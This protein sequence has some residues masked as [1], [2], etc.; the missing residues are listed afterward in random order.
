M[1]DING[2]HFAR[3]IGNAAWWVF[4]VASLI[5][6]GVTWLHGSSDHYQTASFTDPSAVTYHGAYTP[7]DGVTMSKA[8]S[9]TTTSWFES[10]SFYSLAAFAVVVAA[11]LWEAIAGRDLMPGI[12]TVTVPF[13]ALA[14]MG[15]ATPGVFGNLDLDPF[16]AMLLVL[17]AVGLR[18]YWSRT[19]PHLHLTQ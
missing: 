8:Y 3:P 15:L 5:A 11:A 2:S 19:L 7:L 16:P 10:P 1:A 9:S 13:A 4:I 12:L 14:V 18:A 17:A 6:G